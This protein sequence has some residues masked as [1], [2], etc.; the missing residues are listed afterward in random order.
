MYT[1]REKIIKDI[2]LVT[3]YIDSMDGFHDYRIGHIEAKKDQIS[4]IIESDARTPHNEGAY[5]WFLKFKGTADFSVDFDTV[6]PFFIY[7]TRIEHSIFYLDCT[8][9]GISFSFK[10]MTI[11]T[12]TMA[13][14]D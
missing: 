9:G 3:E 14:R 12:P 6:C 10:E 5:T 11:E 7:E 4:V 1:R 2:K 8:N 13:Q